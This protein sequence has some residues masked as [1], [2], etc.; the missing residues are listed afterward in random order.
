MSVHLIISSW[1]GDRRFL[2]HNDRYLSRC[3][4]ELNQR[5]HSLSQVS[6]GHPYNPRMSPNFSAFIN[7]LK[8]LDDGTPIRVLPM[9]NKGMSYGQW[10]EIVRD[11]VKNFDY[12]IFMEDDFGVAIDNFD[13]I[14]INKFERKDNCGL[15]CGMVADP[16]GRYRV[17]CSTRH[18]AISNSI[19]SRVVLEHMLKTYDGNMP[20]L[21]CGY[22]SQVL[23]SNSF[24]KAGYEIHDWL[25]EYRSVFF[26]S[27][28]NPVRLFTE[29]FYK[30]G[31]DIFNPLQTVTM[32]ERFNYTFI[33][34]EMTTGPLTA[35][36]F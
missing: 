32:P 1:S 21:R 12:H 16:D 26:S 4:E 3:L 19:S 34:K 33:S 7:N 22:A 17:S 25:D 5:K 27:N 9:K 31:P 11:E 36:A 18:A 14:L 29:N 6:I 2:G 10:S 13:E 28:Q 24:I 20:Y 35:T 15:L 30:M 8:S 23:W